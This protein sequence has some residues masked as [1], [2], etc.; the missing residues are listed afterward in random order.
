MS[1]T[2]KNEQPIFRKEVADRVSTPEQL[3]EYLRVTNPG[4]W[5]VLIAVL[6]ILIGLIAWSAVGTLEITEPA[7][8]IVHDGT[9]Q[10]VADES[11]TMQKGLTLDVLGQESTI[12][13]I[14]SDDYGRTIGVASVTL[15]DGTYEGTLVMGEVHPIDFLFD[16]L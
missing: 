4:I 5:I 16:S 13:L 11:D 15:P 3:E 9:A 2:P 12:A 1:N 8:I 14:K 7:W 6:F 10:V